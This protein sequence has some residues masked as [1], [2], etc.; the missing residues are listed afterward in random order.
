[1]FAFW[2]YY[3][4]KLLLLETIAFSDATLSDINVLLRYFLSQYSRVSFSLSY[5]G[6]VHIGA[7]ALHV[8]NLI[9]FGNIARLSQW[10]GG[11]ISSFK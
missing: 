11:L 8:L 5:I 7:I 6:G 2:N 1:M 4:L 9:W 10:G 3:V